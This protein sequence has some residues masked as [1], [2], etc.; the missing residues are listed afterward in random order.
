MN[1]SATVLVNTFPGLWSSGLDLPFLRRWNFFNRKLKL[2]TCKGKRH[3]QSILQLKDVNAVLAYVTSYGTY[4]HKQM[5]PPTLSPSLCF[6]P[7]L[8]QY[9]II[10]VAYMFTEASNALP[11]SVVTVASCSQG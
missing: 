1:T 6:P 11:R 8:P 3:N 5:H 4:S 10:Q 9:R 2:S 7:S